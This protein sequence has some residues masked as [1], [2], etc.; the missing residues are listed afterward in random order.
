MNN[1]IKVLHV[2]SDTNIGGAGKYLIT[3]CKNRDKEKYDIKV[4]L[5]SNSLLIPELK[6]TGVEI[7]EI[8]GMR[9]N[10]KD[11]K[12]YKLIKN[13]IESELPKIV[14]THASLVAR[15]AAKKAKCKP[16]IIYTKHCDFEPSKLY[17][18]G[19]V[20]KMFGNFTKKL[21]DCIIATSE[22]TKMNL[23]KQ[24]V[25]ES[26]IVSIPN[27]TDGFKRYSKEKIDEIKRKYNI[28]N[29]K[30]IGYVARL[31]E[32]KGHKNL[33]DAVKIINDNSNIEFKCLIAGDGD[34][35]EEL[36]KYVE[37][38]KIADK[39]DFVGF[40]KD[41]EEFLNIIDIQVNC[42]YLSETTNLALIEG[43][44]IGI[45]SVATNIGGTPDMIT[46]GVNGYVVP[47]QDPD[48]L[49][50]KLIDIIHD[51]ELY[52][53]LSVNSEKIF[54]ERYTSDKFAKSIEDVY[55]KI[56]Q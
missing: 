4:A 26:I 17:K 20:K 55:T 19:I 35:K 44:S 37:E 31:V 43:M 41:V 47:I 49:A 11:F 16:K 30:T 24:G 53:K 51:D 15:L 2:L 25:D 13:V 21:A 23:I 1:K 39:V 42:S 10:S 54:E 45:P 14:H 52:N 7:I 50:E 18:Y 28:N 32:L 36:L 29:E 3:Y 34:Y 40:V 22:H 5:P 56:L 46:D 27:G 48:K 12:S 8:D 6:E 38:F 33:F 9:D